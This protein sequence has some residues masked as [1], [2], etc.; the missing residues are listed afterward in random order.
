MSKHKL[1]QNDI[2]NLSNKFICSD[3]FFYQNQPL[4]FANCFITKFAPGKVNSE[5]DLMRVLFADAFDVY[6][7][8]PQS[9]RFPMMKG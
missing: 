9:L 8:F 6:F 1:Y 7:N 3:N 2:S 4:L 5:F